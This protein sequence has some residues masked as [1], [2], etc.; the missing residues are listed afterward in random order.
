MATRDSYKQ[1]KDYINYKLCRNKVVQMIKEAKTVYY[2][3]IIEENRHDTRALWGCLR[4]INPRNDST[5]TM[6]KTVKSGDIDFTDPIDIAQ[7]FNQLFST[8][9]DTYVSCDNHEQQHNFQTLDQHVRSKLARNTKCVIPDVTHEYV[10]HKLSTQP[11]RATGANGISAKLIKISASHIAAPLTWIINLSLRTGV[12]PATWKHARVSPIYKA[13]DKAECGNYR[14][15]SVLCG[16]SKVIERHVHDALYIYLTQHSLLFSAQSG[17]RHGHSCETAL[18]RMIDIWAAAIDRGDINGV[19]LLDFRKAFDMINHECLLK[20]L[21][22]YQCDD[23]ANMWFRSYLT[24]RTQQ[25]S[26]RGHLS[27]TAAITAGVSQGSILGP[28]LFILYMNDLPHHIHNDID[29]FADDSTLHT[30]G[31]NIEEIQ[32]S[33]QTDLNVITTW[34]TDNKVVI[35][36][37]KT[38]TMLITTQQRRHHLQN[39]QLSITL[40]ELNLQQ[41]NQQKVIGVVVDGNLK[42]REHVNDVYNKISQTLAL[43]RRIKQFLPQ[44]TRILFYNSYIMPHL[45][46]CVTV[47]GGLYQNQNQNSIYLNHIYIYIQKKYLNMISDCKMWIGRPLLRPVWSL[48][49]GPPKL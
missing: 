21:N 30:S 13:G 45:D 15:I 42:W 1:R 17:F 7:T 40:N 33:L 36:T 48:S 6:P 46:Y 12:M 11:N 49:Q 3:N 41:V 14:P 44:W 2:R 38:M 23:N 26:F 8:I 22:I 16:I 5:S 4:E 39:D 29:M 24:G 28:L 47:W 32:L 18:L 19:I 27:E 43:F 31:P 20:K 34:C 25:T 10:L 9:A 35:N 37:S